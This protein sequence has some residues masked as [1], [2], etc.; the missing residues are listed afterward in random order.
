MCF[1]ARGTRSIKPKR[2]NRVDQTV[3][4]NS[5]GFLFGA[6]FVMFPYGN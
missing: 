1:A 5:G 2:K 4:V 3:G 6:G